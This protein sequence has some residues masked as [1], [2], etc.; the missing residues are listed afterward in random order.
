MNKFLFFVLYIVVNNLSR[1]DVLFQ[2]ATNNLLTVCSCQ[3]S[4]LK[5]Y[6]KC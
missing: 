2:A 1:D 6:N 4:D 3:Q 5:A